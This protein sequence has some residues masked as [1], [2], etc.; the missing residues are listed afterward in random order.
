MLAPPVRGHNGLHKGHLLFPIIKYTVSSNLP[1][2]SGGSMVRSGENFCPAPRL[3]SRT[4][5]RMREAHSHGS[6]RTAR[7]ETATAADERIRRPRQTDRL[8]NARRSTHEWQGPRTENLQ[9]YLPGLFYHCERDS[10]ENFR[11]DS[12]DRRPET[13][14]RETRIW[15][16]SLR[17]RSRRRATNRRSGASETFSD[18]QN[19]DATLSACS[20]HGNEYRVTQAART[21]AVGAPLW[22]PRAARAAGVRRACRAQ[23]AR[24]GAVR[25]VGDASGTYIHV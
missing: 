23:V 17:I 21:A 9:L 4:P 1:R 18:S 20:T 7:A 12:G 24:D 13:G 3:M 8:R 10:G 14:D 16:S 2:A 11:G 22:V 15:R 19:D 25:R 5:A 6:R